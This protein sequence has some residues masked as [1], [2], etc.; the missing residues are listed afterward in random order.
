MSHLSDEEMENIK[1]D[2][3]G[4]DKLTPFTTITHNDSTLPKLCSTYTFTLALILTQSF[5]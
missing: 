3:G 1:N 5:T 2:E 4:C